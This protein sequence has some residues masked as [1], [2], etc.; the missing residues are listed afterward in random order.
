MSETR[1]TQQRP[2]PGERNNQE[3]A[4]ENTMKGLP[5]QGADGGNL[6]SQH[7]QHPKHPRRQQRAKQDDGDGIYANGLGRSQL[8]FSRTVEFLRR[9]GLA[10]LDFVV[11]FLGERAGS[12]NFAEANRTVRNP[13]HLR[14]RLDRPFLRQTRLQ[15]GM[16]LKSAAADAQSGFVH[17]GDNAADD[18]AWR[19]GMKTAQDNL[20]PLVK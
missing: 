11:L 5:G 14:I 13:V 12:N 3:G 4:V 8:R 2:Q 16:L 1:E 19:L 6:R 10:P 17:I 15:V 20:D 18:F 9:E 7:L